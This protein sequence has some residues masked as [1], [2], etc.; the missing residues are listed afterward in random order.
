MMPQFGLI[1]NPENRRAAL[2]LEAVE[3]KGLS[4]PIVVSWLEILREPER[5][6]DKLAACDLVRIDSAGENET[7]AHALIRLGGGPADASLQFG[8]LAY[9]REAHLGFCELLDRAAR[10]PLRFTSPPDD[11]KTMFD[12]GLGH[13]RL[14]G[15]AP[16]PPTYQPTLTCRRELREFMAA[17]QLR[18]VF[19]K[20][21]HGSS[22]SGVCAYRIRREREQLIAPIE[23][24]ERAGE[25]R[26]FNSLRVRSYVDPRDIDLILKRIL[27]HGV[28]CETWLRK[29]WT[30]GMACDLRIVTIAGE[31][32]H[33]VVRKSRHAM[34]NL[35]LGNQRG[36]VDAFIAQHGEAAFTTCRSA[37][38]A[39]AACF[40]DSLVIGVDVVLTKRGEVYVLEV[41]AFGDL[42]PEIL[43]RGQSTYEAAVSAMLDSLSE[44]R[45]RSA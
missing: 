37:A 28:V 22:A 45:R 35:H 10:A 24:Q 44:A 5:V 27:P 38:E 19:L 12:K 36:T 41:N 40:P 31:A 29:A 33:T 43:D 9:M 3:S 34:T 20:P 26:L 23:L 14:S 2:F 32:R 39:A 7:L 13:T 25:V 21:L 4:Q 15:H 16:R 30:D 8:E 1:A 42:L 18:R 6:L 11:I 17:N